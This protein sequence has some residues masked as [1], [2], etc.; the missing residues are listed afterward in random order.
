MAFIIFE[1]N[2]QRFRLELPDSEVEKIFGSITGIKIEKKKTYETK[3]QI[4]EIGK[5]TISGEE[6]TELKHPSVEDL[7]NLFK[8]QTNFEFGTELIHE[9]F[10]PNLDK[11]EWRKAY[12]SIYNKI[13]DAMKKIEEQEKGHFIKRK[14]GKFTYYKF[15]KNNIPPLSE[16]QTNV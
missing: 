13:N 4:E 5:E 11:T 2:N 16:Y 9:K 7:I 6:L 15:I 8:T 14:E 3:K 12:Y 10:Y 1:F